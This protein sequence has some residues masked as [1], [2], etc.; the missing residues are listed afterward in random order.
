VVTPRRPLRP[1]TRY[2]VRLRSR[3]IRDRAGN[4]LAPVRWS[5]TTRTA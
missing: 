1:G 3:R 2:T 4:R 5:F